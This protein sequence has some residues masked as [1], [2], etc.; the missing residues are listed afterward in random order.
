MIIT[1][2]PQE[3]LI[4]FGGKILHHDKVIPLIDQYGIKKFDA[5]TALPEIKHPILESIIAIGRTAHMDWVEKTVS[6]VEVII[7]D[8]SVRRFPNVGSVKLRR[9]PENDEERRSV[10]QFV[11]ALDELVK[12]QCQIPHFLGPKFFTN[13]SSQISRKGK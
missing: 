1:Y 11:A 3:G 9:P 8:D 6:C 2:N 4:D 12:E 7:E 5:H 13:P 10:D